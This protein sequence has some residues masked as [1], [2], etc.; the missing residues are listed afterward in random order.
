[1]QAEAR[2]PISSENHPGKKSEFFFFKPPTSNHSEAIPVLLLIYSLD[3]FFGIVYL[4][5]VINIRGVLSRLAK[6]HCDK[7]F[8]MLFYLPAQNSAA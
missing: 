1:L 6:K 8:V 3:K 7:I 5:V 4:A 2:T